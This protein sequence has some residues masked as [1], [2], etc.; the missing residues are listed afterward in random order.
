[1]EFILLLIL[2]LFTLYYLFY[3]QENYTNISDKD[4]I[5]ID[6]IY[7]YINTNP[8]N[9]FVDYIN[10]LANI[11]NTNLDIIDNEVYATFKAAKKR[12]KFT[13]QD[14]IEEMKL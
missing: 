1:M 13:K 3:N 12:N 4:Q 5:T 9:T 2:G 11:K 10:F 8:D 6:Q 14:I 7:D